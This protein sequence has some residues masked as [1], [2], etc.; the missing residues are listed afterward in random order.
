[1][2][3]KTQLKSN[4]AKILEDETDSL[5]SQL[6]CEVDF[7]DVEDNYIMIDGE[8]V[9]L[10]VSSKELQRLHKDGNSD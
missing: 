3:K 10:S 8:A 5:L 1:M 6:N 4:L 7:K 9:S 2:K